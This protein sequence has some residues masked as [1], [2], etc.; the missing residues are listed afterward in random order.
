[1]LKK[2]VVSH[3][4]RQLEKG[5]SHR[6]QNHLRL[7]APKKKTPKKLQMALAVEQFDDYMEDSYNK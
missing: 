7:P 3:W 6:H 4:A 5:N 2:L 1:M